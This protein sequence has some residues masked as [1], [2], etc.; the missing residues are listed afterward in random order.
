MLPLIWS[1]LGTSSNNCQLKTKVPLMGPQGPKF[2]EGLATVDPVDEFLCLIARC[3]PLL[4]ESINRSRH[5]LY[6]HLQRLSICIFI[7]KGYIN[8]TSFDIKLVY[9]LTLFFLTGKFTYHYNF[10]SHV[11]KFL[12]SPILGRI[13]PRQI[14]KVTVVVHY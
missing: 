13:I 8:Y 14:I 2:T 10:Q 12:Q 5:N 11:E 3:D 4:L 6:S 7:N 1:T 9:T